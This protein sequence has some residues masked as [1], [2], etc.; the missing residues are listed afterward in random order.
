MKKLFCLLLIGGTFIAFTSCKKTCTCDTYFNGK[1]IATV[2]NV[3][4]TE[5]FKKCSDMNTIVDTPT[6]G[7]NGVKCK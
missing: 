1:V 6:L 7:K 4:L 3:E 2:H 5:D